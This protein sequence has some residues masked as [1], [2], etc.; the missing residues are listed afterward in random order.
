MSAR[1]SFRFLVVAPISILAVCM[2]H[3]ASA[4]P[5][6]PA[7]DKNGNVTWGGNNINGRII[8]TDT[9]L[10][11]YAIN[12]VWTANGVPYTGVYAAFN[13][14]P[15]KY[16][17]RLPPDGNAINITDWTQTITS[18]GGVFGERGSV[19]ESGNVKQDAWSFFPLADLTIPGSWEIPDL[20]PADA[21]L[22]I[23]AA[24]D[25]PLYYASNPR[26]FLN[27]N[28]SAGQTLDEL[29][30]KIVDGTISGIQGIYFATTGFILDPNSATGWVPIGGDGAL[31]NSD[32]FE[33]Q[34]GP[35]MI[36]AIHRGVPEPASFALFFAGI[37]ILIAFGRTMA[38]AHRCQGPPKANVSQSPENASRRRCGISAPTLNRGVPG[39]SFTSRCGIPERRQ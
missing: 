17:F 38:C 11:G 32:T 4:G 27:G 1:G 13:K 39:R 7:V 35:I 12:F 26:G 14:G 31:L 21:P 30:I 5:V 34:N 33:Q 22:T 20:L 2:I 23:Y 24:V 9:V 15:G 8:V 36:G 6:V 29:G 10:Q 16:T 18:T 25:L 3:P 28:Y 19:V 37:G